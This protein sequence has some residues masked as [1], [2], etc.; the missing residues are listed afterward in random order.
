MQNLFE[1]DIHSG[2]IKLNREWIAMVPEFKE[3]IQAKTPSRGD[4]ENKKKLHAIKVFTYIFML[5]D[6][7]SPLRNMDPAE[8][9]KEALRVSELTDKD[10]NDKV[11]KALATYEWYQ[12]NSARSLRTL[13]AMRG[14]LDKADR[15]FENVDFSAVDKKGELKYSMKDYQAVF[16]NMADTYK[17]FEEFERRVYEELMQAARTIRGQRSLGGKEGTRKEW[18]EGKRPE[19]DTKRIQELTKELSEMG[20]RMSEED[21]PDPGIEDTTEEEE[22]IDGLP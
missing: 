7:K 2:F 14:S 9:V 4:T 5:V 16:K 18:Q 21:E 22:D 6:F 12:E 11:K 15:Y 19:A 8:K 17:S 1:F 3:I 10:I 20:I 13:K